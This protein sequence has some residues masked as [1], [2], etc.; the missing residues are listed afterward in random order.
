MRLLIFCEFSDSVKFQPRGAKAWR[1]RRDRSQE[2]GV[3]RVPPLHSGKHSTNLQLLQR[4]PPLHSD[5]GPLDL[6]WYHKIFVCGVHF[7]AHNPLTGSKFS[8]LVLHFYACGARFARQNLLSTVNFR[9]RRL[10]C[11]AQSP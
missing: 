11:K 10:F 8:T 4:V 5:P 7:V 1:T 9:L 6:Q 2:K 3:E